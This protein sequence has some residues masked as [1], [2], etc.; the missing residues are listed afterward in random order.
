MKTAAS[1][2]CYSV[3]QKYGEVL[4]CGSMWHS[5]SAKW[6]GTP[7]VW[8]VIG[9]MSTMR[10]GQNI[11]TQESRVEIGH[12]AHCWSSFSMP[13]SCTLP[14]T[15]S[16]Y[17]PEIYWSPLWMNSATEHPQPSVVENSQIPH[18]NKGISP[19]SWRAAL[20]VRARVKQSICLVWPLFSLK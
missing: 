17:Y 15:W 8:E 3:T 11:R 20:M 16:L 5:F 19:L 13:H 6:T 10:L 7:M 18:L 12:P 9:F 14:V 1:N 2:G 4:V